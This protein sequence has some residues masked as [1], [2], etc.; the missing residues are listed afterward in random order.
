MSGSSVTLHPSTPGSRMG[1]TRRR[2][3]R[4]ARSKSAK[5]TAEVESE[6]KCRTG[7]WRKRKSFSSV[8][9]VQSVYRVHRNAAAAATEECNG[10]QSMFNLHTVSP[11]QADLEGFGLGSL[12][13][14]VVE[15]MEGGNS[16]HKKPKERMR[17]F[18][19]RSASSC[20]PMK[21]K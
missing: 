7:H 17:C 14:M 1:V 3:P 20:K 12:S 8:K 4:E 9:A 15:T 21:L 16:E 11:L 18:M 2:I 13:L 10:T 6:T 19:P 5:T